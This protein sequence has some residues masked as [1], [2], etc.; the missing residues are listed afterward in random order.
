MHAQNSNPAPAPPPAPA[1]RKAFH[2]ARH[3]PPPAAAPASGARRV[4]TSHTR[5]HSS[6]DPVASRC[7]CKG[8]NCADVTWHKQ[9]TQSHQTT[10]R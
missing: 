3:T 7:S 9:H 2:R 8:W 6:Y 4:R 10:Q 1:G 5:T